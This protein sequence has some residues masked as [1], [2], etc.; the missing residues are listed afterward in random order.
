MSEQ[1]KLIKAGL[2]QFDYFDKL[3]E[4]LKIRM[5]AEVDK[6]H[7]WLRYSIFDAL[8]NIG[9]GLESFEQAS[10]F[11]TENCT[12]YSNDQIGYNKLCLKNDEES[13]PVG[14]FE[15]TDLFVVNKNKM[16]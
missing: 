4:R 6:Y 12:V 16:N 9:L 13:E 3:T 14:I 1:E 15:W 8:N 5:A 11:I 7:D 10:K 2:T